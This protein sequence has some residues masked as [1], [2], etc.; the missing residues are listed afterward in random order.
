MFPPNFKPC[1]R[2][3]ILGGFSHRLSYLNPANP[4][5]N[6]TATSSAAG[7]E[8][9]FSMLS[10]A[11]NPPSCSSRDAEAKIPSY[12]KRQESQSLHLYPDFSTWKF[13]KYWVSPLLSAGE[14]ETQISEASLEEEW[15][16]GARAM[17]TVS[18]K[19]SPQIFCKAHRK[20]RPCSG[21]GGRHAVPLPPPL[22]GCW[23]SGFSSKLLPFNSHAP[24][25]A[26]LPHLSP[27]CS[28]FSL[29]QSDSSTSLNHVTQFLKS[30][31]ST[32][33]VLLGSDLT[34]DDHRAW[35]EP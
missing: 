10:S 16:G 27:M 8:L 32:D 28:L 2:S 33:A 34:S 18:A 9:S 29:Q 22:P 6:G 26:V 21:A 17:E 35:S 23:S 24:L 13:C 19:P 31:P 1:S 14:L 15:H 3:V 4:N 25:R 20:P 7:Q 12:E 5:P 30:L 11:R